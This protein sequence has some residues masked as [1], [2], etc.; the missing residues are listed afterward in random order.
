MGLEIKRIESEDQAL[1]YK[2][3]VE[4]LTELIKMNNISDFRKLI[5]SINIELHIWENK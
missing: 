1:T 3:Y 2:R 4:S 5:D